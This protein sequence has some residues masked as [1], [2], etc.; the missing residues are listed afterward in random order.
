MTVIT[1]GG[2][3]NWLLI[4]VA[5]ILIG[6]T[7][8]GRRIG[9]IRTVFTLFSTV[10][11]IMLTVW[12]SPVINK[13]VQQN[14]KVMNYVEKKISQIIDFKD[15][16]N[17]VTDQVSFINK[18]PMPKA[19]RESLIENNNKEV[20]KTMSVK[21]FKE[22]VSESVSRMIINSGVFICVFLIISI[23]LGIICI[24]LNII[25]KLPVINGLNKTAGLLAGLIQGIVVVWIGF[26]I[27]TAFAGT[28][29]GQSAF[30][31]IN[32]NTFLSVLYNNNMLLKFV[33]NLG[34]IL[35]A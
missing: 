3:A 12:V 18:L 30:E 17:K 25:S 21:N 5:A 15:T 23:A 11:A 4:V 2:S 28:K 1:A 16:G 32:N 19:M 6:F 26:L 27:L 33:M 29:V 10:I 8:N 20:Y 24:A 13:E 22:Y 14:E 34:Q 9:F 35:L 7:V 31:L